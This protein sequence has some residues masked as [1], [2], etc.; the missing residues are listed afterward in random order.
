MLELKRLGVVLKP[1]DGPNGRFAKFA[2]AWLLRMILST[3]CRWSEKKSTNGRRQNIPRF[4]YLRNHISYARLSLEG[5]WHSIQI[6]RP[7][8]R[9]LLLR[10]ADVKTPG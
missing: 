2:R 6:D 1:K 5:N 10:Q 7:S 8:T 9:P 3:C 4:A